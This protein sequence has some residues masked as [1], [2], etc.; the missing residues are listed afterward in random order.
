ME[1]DCEHRIFIET[2][3]INLEIPGKFVAHTINRILFYVIY[4]ISGF[5]SVFRQ[6]RL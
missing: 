3:S 2:P 1:F 4:E 5:F 6:F